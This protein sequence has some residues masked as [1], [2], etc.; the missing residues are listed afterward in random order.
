MQMDDY[1]HSLKLM[2]IFKWSGN[3]VLNN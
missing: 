1:V 3:K 2:R